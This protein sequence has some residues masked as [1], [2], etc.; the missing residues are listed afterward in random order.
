MQKKSRHWALEH[1]DIRTGRATRINLNTAA[2]LNSGTW[3]REQR[4]QA[5]IAACW[6]L[7]GLQACLTPPATRSDHQNR[8]LAA[9]VLQS[10]LAGHGVGPGPTHAGQYRPFIPP[11]DW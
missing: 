3:R 7:L 4:A 9:L 10:I 11:S 1:W 5:S 8:H 6:A 2:H